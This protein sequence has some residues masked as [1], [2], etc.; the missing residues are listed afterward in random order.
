MQDAHIQP[1]DEKSVREAEIDGGSSGV[2]PAGTVM[3]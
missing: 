1:R 2:D 3:N